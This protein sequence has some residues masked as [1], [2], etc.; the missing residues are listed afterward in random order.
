MRITNWQLG[1]I[2]LASGRPRYAVYVLRLARIARIAAPPDKQTSPTS[3]MQEGIRK[4]Y[5]SRPH[6]LTGEHGDWGLEIG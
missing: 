4:Y 3:C 6:P 2:I 5:T 1:Y